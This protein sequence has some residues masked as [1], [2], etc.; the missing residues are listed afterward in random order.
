MPSRLDTTP[1]SRYTLHSAAIV[2]A[3]DVARLAS[4]ELVPWTGGPN[5]GE[6]LVRPRANHGVPFDGRITSSSKHGP[7]GFKVVDDDVYVYAPSTLGG[8]T[9]HLQ[10]RDRV[11]GT[12]VLGAAGSKYKWRASSVDKV[13]RASSALHKG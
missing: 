3:C 9:P 10:L 6:M 11:I 13:E 4:Q 12:M 1:R 2:S 8:V 7:S 5:K